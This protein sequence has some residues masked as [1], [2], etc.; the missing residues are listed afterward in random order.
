MSARG[1]RERPSLQSR[2]VLVFLAGRCIR[3]CVI[4][5][6]NDGL[7][8]RGVHG[9]DAPCPDLDDPEGMRIVARKLCVLGA[10]Q[11][12][13]APC[14]ADDPGRAGAMTLRAVVD[15]GLVVTDG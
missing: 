15:F 11:A 6:S 3:L 12:D 7:A 5:A 9:V 14:G 2:W 4:G 13:C 8:A 10:S 1:G